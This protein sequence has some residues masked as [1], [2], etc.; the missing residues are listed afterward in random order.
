MTEIRFY[1]LQHQSQAQV[2]SVILLKALERGHR[3]LVKMRNAAEIAQMNDYLWTFSPDSFLPHGSEK[4]GNAEMQPIWITAEDENPNK[5]DVLIL[6]QGVVSGQQADFTLCC[7]M[8]DGHD[9]QAI[10]D[11][12]ARWKTYKEQG[13]EVTYWQQ[14]EAGGWEKKA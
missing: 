6:C 14:S 4:N 1:H 2:L 13:F 9:H 7:E 3:I 5:A 8:L 12:R 10:S 11:A